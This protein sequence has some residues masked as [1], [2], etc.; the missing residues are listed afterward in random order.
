MI[1]LEHSVSGSE[2]GQKLAY[3]EEELG[4]AL[5]AVMD[6]IKDAKALGQELEGHLLADDGSRLI[7]FL[8][9][10]ADGIEEAA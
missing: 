1:S 7:V 4:Y 10:L 5:V 8:R 9:A 6:T 2:L 3:D